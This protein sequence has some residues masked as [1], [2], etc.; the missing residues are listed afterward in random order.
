MNRQLLI[1]SH[2]VFVGL[3]P[4]I[5]IP[6][7]DDLVKN[8]FYQNMVRSLAAAHNISLTQAEINVLAEE[9]GEGCLNGCV[10]GLVEYLV[11]RLI[12]KIVFVLEWRRAVNLVTH[13]YYIG[14]LLDYAFEQGWYK[15][16]DVK[17]AM[18]LRTAIERARRGA[19]TNL[20][21]RVVQSSFDQSRTAIMGAVDQVSRSV[22]DITLRRSRIWL[23]Q[24]LAVRLRQF[25]PRLSRWFYK[26]LRP[27]A[28]E[29][30]HVAEVEKMVAQTLER[31][32]PSFGAPL[33]DM[34]EYLQENLNAVPR[35]HFETLE[36][37]LAGAMM[38]G[39]K[40]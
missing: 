27:D 10:F 4:L 2:S 29:I 1:V 22:Q 19:N 13:V 7:V 3:S 18:Q 40:G 8:F 9:R 21:K 5:P 34:I 12:R 25:S 31:E 17:S 6:I 20:V 15:P 24:L 36:Q 11:K 26:R 39:A 16:A 35:E 33:R 37:R 23:R 14:H 38:L 28:R 32:T 30:A